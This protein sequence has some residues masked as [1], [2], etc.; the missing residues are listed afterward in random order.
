MAKQKHDI[1]YQKRLKNK[2]EKKRVEALELSKN[3]HKKHWKE[4]R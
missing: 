1:G 4:N 3:P 2:A